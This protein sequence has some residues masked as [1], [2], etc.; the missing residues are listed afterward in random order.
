MDGAAVGKAGVESGAV[1]E[2]FNVV[3]DGGA[4]FRAGGEAVVIDPEKRR[5]EASPGR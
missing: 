2:G 4:G 3:E 5:D 1:V